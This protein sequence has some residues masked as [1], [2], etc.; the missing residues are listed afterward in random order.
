MSCGRKEP[1]AAANQARS[2]STPHGGIYLRACLQFPQQIAGIERKHSIVRLR[3]KLGERFGRAARRVECQ[4]LLAEIGRRTVPL[5]RGVTKVPHF[6]CASI[7][8]SSASRRSAPVTVTGPTQSV[9]ISAL[10]EGRRVPFSRL[11]QA[12]E[13]VE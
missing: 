5:E 7:T 6:G 1:V 8:P 13:D 10:T 3:S 4:G 11:R 9:R 2:A 12:G